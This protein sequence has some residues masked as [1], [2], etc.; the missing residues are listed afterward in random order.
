LKVGGGALGSR[1][2]YLGHRFV[3][4]AALAVAACARGQDQTYKVNS[5]SAQQPQTPKAQ[6]QS[7]EKAL[8]WGSNIQNARLS[9][10]AEAA[11]RSHNYAAA[12]DYAQR[13]AQSAPNDA[14]LWFLLGYAARLAGKSHLNRWRR[15]SFR[16]ALHGLPPD[17]LADWALRGVFSEKEAASETGASA[18]DERGPVRQSGTQG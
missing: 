11:L 15:R 10:A 3:L 5:G 9:H 17:A 6:S 1:I 14:Q 7:A 12:V 4:A 13:A 8:G 16:H 18:R 2:Q